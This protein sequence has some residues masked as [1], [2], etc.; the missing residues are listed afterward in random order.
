MYG[1][2]LF[3]PVIALTVLTMLFHP[4]TGQWGS[5]I[6]DLAGLFNIV[7]D[8]PGILIGF[9]HIFFTLLING[10]S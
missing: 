3:I 10:L 6:K 9:N 2:V 1:V 8:R 7:A 5:S 4:D